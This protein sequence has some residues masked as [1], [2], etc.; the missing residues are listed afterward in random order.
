M[1]GDT[2]N[3]AYVRNRPTG[4]TDPLGLITTGYQLLNVSFGAGIGGGTT[5]ALVADDQGQV[6][7]AVTGGVGSYGGIGASA[8]TGAQVTNA[9]TIQDLRGAGT[10]TS[11]SVNSGPV[12]GPVAVVGEAGFFTGKG[13]QGGMTGVGLGIGTPFAYTG[14]G[15]GTVIA[16]LF[17][18]VDRNAAAVAAPPPQ[19]QMPLPK[20]CGRKC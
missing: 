15:T 3:Y 13:Y 20:A 16:C 8:T 4:Y 6:G 1:S 17:N 7:L 14:F 2:N 10:S 9:A 19:G 12:I 18:C 11:F 5:L